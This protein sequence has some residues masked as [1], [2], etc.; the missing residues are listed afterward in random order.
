M[1][2][3]IAQ[4]L[5]S[6]GTLLGVLGVTR[7]CGRQPFTTEEFALLDIFAHQATIAIMNARSYTQAQHARAAAEAR[8][9]Q[10]AVLI[11]VSNAVSGALD[12]QRCSRA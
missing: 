2:A 5:L 1:T 10:L 6:A 12:G 7:A 11:A 4:P 3:V 8:A 9:Q